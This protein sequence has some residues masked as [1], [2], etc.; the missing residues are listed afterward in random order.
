M[1]TSS[2][3]AQTSQGSSKSAEA[4]LSIVF[5]VGAPE[6]ALL[7]RVAAS[8]TVNSLD[9]SL[10]YVDL[11]W[12]PLVWMSCSALHGYSSGKHLLERRCRTLARFRETAKW[13]PWTTCLMLKVLWIRVSN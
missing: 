3:A 12:Q 7:T 9:L 2:S 6:L 13:M 10:V 1:A 11:F 5:L 4:A 8:L